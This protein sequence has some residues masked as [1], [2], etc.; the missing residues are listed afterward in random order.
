MIHEGAPYR[1]PPRQID[2]QPAEQTSPVGFPPSAA[3]IPTFELRARRQ[4]GL[5]PCS[6]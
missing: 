4:P 2:S 3:F 6:R 5:T 1:P